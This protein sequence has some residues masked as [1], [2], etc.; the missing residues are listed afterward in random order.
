MSRKPRT[1]VAADPAVDSL[2]RSQLPTAAIDRFKW[3]A[4]WLG[5]VASTYPRPWWFSDRSLVH[6]ENRWEVR[7]E[8]LSRVGTASNSAASPFCASEWSRREVRSHVDLMPRRRERT[9]LARWEREPFELL[10]REMASLFESPWLTMTWEPE[11]W[12]FET[13]ERE[14]EVVLR[15]EMPGFELD[16]IEVT[17]RGNELTVRAEHRESAEEK[18]KER[19]HA[20]LERTVT[21]PAG[22]EPGKVE[23]RY[24]SGVLE[25]HVPRAP[26]ATPRRIEVKT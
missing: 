3:R 18:A 8:V 2:A 22:V 14:G 5:L 9:A 13:E 16:E 1:A 17:L 12:G 25:V 19:R 26:E 20:R 10:R 23:A 15:T 7:R 21:L 6:D 24:H 4:H 11:P